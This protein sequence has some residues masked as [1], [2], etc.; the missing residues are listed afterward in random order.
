ME[1]TLQLHAGLD[2]VE[3]SAVLSSH[4]FTLMGLT[5]DQLRVR[6]FFLKLKSLKAS[7][8]MLLNSP[9]KVGVTPPPSPVPKMSPT[10]VSRHYDTSGRGQ[11]D[12]R[13]SPSASTSSSLKAP[14]G[15]LD[16]PSSVRTARAC[17]TVDRDVLEYAKCLRRKDMDLLLSHEVG[18]SLST[19]DGSMVTLSGKS[20][21]TL[22][23][24]KALLD[25][26]HRTL[27]TQCVPLK[28]LSPE[29]RSLAARIQKNSHVYGS[30]LVQ[31]RKTNLHLVGPSADSYLLKQLLLGRTVDQDPRTGRTM[32]RKPTRRSS[33]LPPPSRR[34]QGAAAAAYS[35][36][37]YQDLKQEAAEG[38]HRRARLLT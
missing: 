30:V 14:P 12:K 37:K 17:F 26:L 19:V 5:G 36:S 8:E 34:G 13:A 27:R 32:D 24:L 21:N 1:A 35:P 31:R 4:G 9:A 29:G 6:G 25:N 28:D 16:Q 22:N 15:T 2:R 38:P 33:S 11:M 7:L 18:V 3:V 20:S 23:K 10:A